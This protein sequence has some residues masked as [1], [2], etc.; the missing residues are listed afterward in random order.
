V[1]LRF[2]DSSVVLIDSRDRRRYRVDPEA[3]RAHETR[4][5]VRRPE[6]LVLRAGESATKDYVFRVPAA[7]VEP[8]LRVAPG[9]WLGLLAEQ[10]LIGTR[11]FQL[12]DPGATEKKTTIFIGP[13]VR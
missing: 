12:G 10:L 13:A 11:E 6:T 2:N 4:V 7:V 1:P 3:Q 5:G 9:G 8:R